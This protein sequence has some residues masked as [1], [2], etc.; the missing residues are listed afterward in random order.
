MRT[1][2]KDTEII[3]H[4]SLGSPYAVKAQTMLSFTRQRYLSV[5]ASKGVPR[6]V[7]KKLVGSYS[8]RIPILQIG[9]DMFCDTDM[10]ATEIATIGNQPELSSLHQDSS[11]IEF[12]N[13]VENI[14]GNA[15]LGLLTKW[16]FIKGYFKMIPAKHALTFLKDRAK[17]AKQFKGKL[18][19]GNT[20]NDLLA[21]T[22]FS[23]I[24]RILDK[25]QYLYSD[26]KPTAIDFTCYTHIWYANKLRNL[27]LE[28]TY[29]K[30]SIWLKKMDMIG[31]GEFEEINP[32]TAVNV[33]KL[34]SPRYISKD[35][36]KTDGIGKQFSFTPNDSLGFICDPI[37]GTLVG[38]DDY[39]YIIER[40]TDEV[41]TVNI[42]IPKKCYGACG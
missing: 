38:E 33:A 22:F 4:R 25:K 11:T 31:L 18:N 10:I 7:Q 28:T 24:E 16:Q 32:E 41:G 34:N 35:M 36:T 13:N 5:V 15:L 23:E 17:L 20:D 30:T 26:N 29:P 40:R 1:D 39:K 19:S 3:L 37:T 2:I 12:I 21:K 42:H 8:R 6:P 14:Y 9:A 27:N